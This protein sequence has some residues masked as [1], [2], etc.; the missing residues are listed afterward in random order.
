[1]YI[2]NVSLLYLFIIVIFFSLIII[3]GLIWLL[4]TG[5][6]NSMLIMMVRCCKNIS[7]FT[8]SLSPLDEAQL[9]VSVLHAAISKYNVGLKSSLY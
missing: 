2:N 7:I 9:W 6:S 3:Q 5:Y 4:L 8:F 1:M